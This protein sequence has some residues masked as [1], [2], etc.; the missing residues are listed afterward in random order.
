VDVPML[1][2]GETWL[3][4]SNTEFAQA[5]KVPFEKS[6]SLNTCI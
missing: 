5:S 6:A 1:A 4:E 2:H 3:Y